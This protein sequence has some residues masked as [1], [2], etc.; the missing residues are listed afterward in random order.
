ML[1]DLL[2]STSFSVCGEE[3]KIF[4]NKNIYR[5]FEYYKNNIDRGFKLS[6]LHSYGKI[7]FNFLHKYGLNLK[8]FKEILENS[9]SL[10]EFV[11]IFKLKYLALRGKD[12]NGILFEKTPENLNTIKE[13][14]DHF[15]SFFI[16]IVRNPIFV[17]KSLKRR[18]FPDYISLLTWLVDNAKLAKYMK[19]EKVIVV[20]YEELV[21]NPFETV[22][23]IFKKIGYTISTEELREWYLSN[24]YRKYC[25][26]KLKE[27]NVKS[28]GKIVNANLLEKVTKEDLEKMG[29]LMNVKIS[30]KYAEFFDV[31]EFSFKELCD[32]F[33]YDI[34]F[35]KTTEIPK[36]SISEK[37]WMLNR[38]KYDMRHGEAIKE[39]R[40]YYVKVIERI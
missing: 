39:D 24:N 38:W 22:K 1:A 19:N 20:K 26:I 21:K 11:N 5:D 8:E 16:A 31:G 27:W 33:G 29:M 40:D 34:D 32:F 13:F 12:I 35:I 17:Y 23:N 28:F 4:A 6:F 36:P 10:K 7:Y 37:K 15:D 2:D 3:T 14:L 18:G 9:N 25:S 30:K